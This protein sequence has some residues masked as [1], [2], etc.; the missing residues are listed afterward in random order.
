MLLSTAKEPAEMSKI[1]ITSI[2]R[3]I[4]V[5]ILQSTKKESS[6]NIELIN[7]KARTPQQVTNN[8]LKNISDK[9]LIRLKDSVVE[10]SSKQRV[11]IAISAFKLGADFERVCKALDWME[12]E[13]ITAMAF[14]INNF[15]VKRRFRFKWAERRWEIDVLG[16]RKPL[17]VCVDCKHW[18]HGWKRSKIVKTVELQV[19]RTKVLATALTSLHEKLGVSNWKHA[20]LVPVVLSLVFAPFKFY[21]SVPIVPILQLQNFL[22]ELPV[23]VTTLSHSTVRLP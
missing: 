17:V 8:I 15:I 5:C 22:N 19:E 12:F 21:R 7:K 6:I 2:E 18:L 11:Q 9:G 1:G 13:N 10:A 20:T 16:C 23:H 3:R 4:L 14:E